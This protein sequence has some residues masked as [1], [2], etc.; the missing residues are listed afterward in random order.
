MRYPRFSEGVYAYFTTIN[1]DQ[2]P[3]FPYILG[4]NFY[5]LPVDSNY[6]S[7][8]N[9]NDIPKKSRRLNELGMPGNGEGVIA[10]IGSVKPGTVDNVT[11]ERSANVF[12]VN[13][14]LYFDNKGTDGFQAEALAES[15]KGQPVEYIDSYENKVVKLTTIQNAYLFEDDI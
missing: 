7:N 2:V 5:S 9:Q 6:N 12:S 11:V 10:E 1:S 14:K 8:I 15:V 13:S 4:K 3:Q